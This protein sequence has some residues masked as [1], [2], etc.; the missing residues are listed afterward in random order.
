MSIKRIK[1]S[2]I[3][4]IS[5]LLLILT[6]PTLAES[7]PDV[8]TSLGKLLQPNKGGQNTVSS[9]HSQVR[10]VALVIGNSDYKHTENLPK[11][12]NAT[13]DAEDISIAL[14]SFGFEVIER[15]NQSLEGMN[16]AIAEFGR[17]IEKSDAALFYFAGHGI[18]VKNQNYL[19]PTDA[20]V[21]S[22]AA[23]AYQGVNV[24]QILDEMDGAKSPANIVMLDACR[25]NPVAGGK[26]RSGKSRGLASPGVPPKGTVI[27]YATDPGNVAADGEGRNGLFT[28]G[29]LTAFKGGDLSLDG[30]LTVASAEVERISG[31]TQSP[32]V[33]GPKT[34]QKN[35]NFKITVEP[36]KAEIERTFWVSIEKS[37]NVAD[38]E[39][40]LKKYPDGSYK[41]LA[42]NKILQLNKN[43]IRNNTF[44]T[45]LSEKKY[46]L[47]IGNSKYKFAPLYNTGLDAMAVRTELNNLGFNVRLLLD[48]DKKSLLKGINEF[49]TIIGVERPTVVVVYYAGHG[50]LVNGNDYLVPLFSDLIKNENDVEEKAVVLADVYEMLGLRSLKSINIFIHD[51]GRDN[52]FIRN[53]TVSSQKKAPV[54]AYDTPN[55]VFLFASSPGYVAMDGD[56]GHGMFTSSLLSNLNT[57]DIDLKQFSRNIRSEVVIKSKGEQE[58]VVSGDMFALSDFKFSATGSIGQ[59]K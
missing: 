56:D 24:N 2:A 11:L 42:D 30:V 12:E 5:G 44:A 35:F 16:Q 41:S 52:P 43:K 26:F 28:S 39:A 34:L 29:L 13:N 14:R 46:A 4:L 48:T 57:P 25:N 37:N 50:F 53:S 54:R 51:A 9:P 1:L 8:L 7:Q 55:T 49:S 38:F 23:V 58:P 3:S 21:E 6:F 18:Q 10:R 45:K 36:G 47:V 15:K 19:M 32:Y 22:E 33:N 31:N 20:K 40:Y 17:K 59:N 27:V